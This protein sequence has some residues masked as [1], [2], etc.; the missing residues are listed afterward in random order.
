MTGRTIC[1]IRR[2]ASGWAG[3]SAPSCRCRARRS[4]M[5]GR[6]STRSAYQPGRRQ[7]GARRA[8]AAGHD[9]R[10]A[11]R[12]D[13]A[14]AALLCG[15]RRVGAR[16]WLSVDR[17]ARRQQRSDRRAQPGRILDRGAGAR[18]SA[19]SGSCRSSTRGNIYTSP[20]PSFTGLPLRRRDRAC[21]IIRTSGRS[22]SMSARRSTRSRAIARIAVY[23]SLGQ[24]F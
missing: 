13:R 24:A 21:A 17:A 2:A 15:R 6:R 4:A 3:G 18:R 23:V 5:R 11:A 12:P 8:D 1:S 7:R 10:R 22:A 20:L 14:V 19:I 9:R 16:L